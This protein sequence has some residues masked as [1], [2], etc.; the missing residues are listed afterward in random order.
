[1]R[2]QIEIVKPFAHDSRSDYRVA[3]I[4]GEEDL[5]AEQMLQAVREIKKP[6]AIVINEKERFYFLQSKLVP[7]SAACQLASLTSEELPELELVYEPAHLGL[8]LDKPLISF[9]SAIP[10]EFL[11]SPSP[12]HIVTVKTSHAIIEIDSLVHLKE[13]K[14]NM[15]LIKEFCER[16]ALN[17]LYFFT[18]NPYR[19]DLAGIH[20]RHFNPWAQNNEDTVHG[21]AAAAL[22]GYLNHYSNGTE[23]YFVIESGHAGD[24]LSLT[25]GDR[26]CYVEVNVDNNITISGKTIRERVI[27]ASIL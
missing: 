23:K 20:A 3:V 11:S 12:I 17:G 9:I 14:P 2:I 4:R 15:G 7:Y 8:T 18:R 19:P 13:L 26:L 6:E 22:G 24:A 27:E 1:M 5:S 10:Q 25:H 21:T 16:S